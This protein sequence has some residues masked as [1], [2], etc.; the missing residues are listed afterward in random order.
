MKLKKI[1]FMLLCSTAGLSYAQCD[2]KT[3]DQLLARIKTG[4]IYDLYGF[5]DTA[6][7]RT[8]AED[9]PFKSIPSVAQLNSWN[10]LISCTH[11]Y[12]TEQIALKKAPTIYKTYL[13]ELEST[14]KDI[15][16]LIKLLNALY[17]KNVIVS[18][19]IKLKTVESYRPLS[20][21]DKKEL[22]LLIKKIDSYKNIIN[23]IFILSLEEI[24]TA[25]GYPAAWKNEVS[26]SLDEIF[27]DFPYFFDTY[28]E[29]K[30]KFKNMSPEELVYF[31][32]ISNLIKA[33]Y[34]ENQ[35]EYEFELQKLATAL[36][37]KLEKFDYRVSDE[38]KKIQERIDNAW[39][40]SREDK[41]RLAYLKKLSADTHEIMNALL[42]VFPLSPRYMDMLARTKD[43]TS[44]LIFAESA[45]L[46]S[47]LQA[48]KRNALLLK[49][50]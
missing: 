32:R 1:L 17:S 49:G 38:A 42:L 37:N 8:F 2:K 41:Q 11:K 3:F 6:K 43:A 28:Q 12:I 4:Y 24:V 48:L 44:L 20:A 14:T 45:A 19:N 50:K 35:R 18:Q 36:F 29:A 10:S 16:A 7:V 23:S 21:A 27:N 31:L 26:S 33:P 39:I 47:E 30:K 25:A 34:K 22:E 13:K 15:L 40:A 9:N 46:T 5:I